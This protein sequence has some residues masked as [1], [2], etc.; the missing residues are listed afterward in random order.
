MPYSGKLPTAEDE[1]VLQESFLDSL[2]YSTELG[3]T[4]KIPF[5]TG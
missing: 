3:Q 2:G 1:I 5:L 4:I